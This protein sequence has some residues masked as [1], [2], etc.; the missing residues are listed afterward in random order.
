MFKVLAVLTI[1]VMAGTAS[2]RIT[3]GHYQWSTG[4][5]SD[6]T[7]YGS[8]RF[9]VDVTEFMRNQSGPVHEK[10][11]ESETARTPTREIRR[12]VQLEWGFVGFLYQKEMNNEVPERFH[13]D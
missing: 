2:G 13:A 1:S 5:L 7:R 4:T 11:G 10:G 9:F 3:A 6:G 8:F 12:T